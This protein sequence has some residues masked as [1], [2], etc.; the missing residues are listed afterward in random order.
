MINNT[1]QIPKNQL[2]A[3]FYIITTKIIQNTD[4][5]LTDKLRNTLTLTTFTKNVIYLPLQ[6]THV[7]IHFLKF[8]MLILNRS[9]LFGFTHDDSLIFQPNLLY[10]LCTYLKSRKI[11]YL[12]QQWNDSKYFQ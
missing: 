2:S 7:T 11:F 1:Q 10:T 12:L 3:N 8:E 4:Y 5:N 6:Y 9:S